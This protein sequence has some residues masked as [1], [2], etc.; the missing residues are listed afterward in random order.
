MRTPE[1]GVADVERI[2]GLGLRGVMLP[3]IP[4]VEDYDSPVYDRLWDAVIDLGAAGVVPHPHR[5]AG[6][7]GG[8]ART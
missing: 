6:R 4:G 2:A 5:R 3:G 7:S 1:E 8:G